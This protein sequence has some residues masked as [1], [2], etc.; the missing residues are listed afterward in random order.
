MLTHAW[1]RSVLICGGRG[2]KSGAQAHSQPASQSSFGSSLIELLKLTDIWELTYYIKL[3]FQ[4]FRLCPIMP[5]S[6]FIYKTW[7]LYETHK[8]AKS[9]TSHKSA[10][11]F[12]PGKNRI[13]KIR[14]KSGS[15]IPAIFD[16]ILRMDCQKFC[17]VVKHRSFFVILT[18]FEISKIAICQG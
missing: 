12:F 15:G 14:E 8:M 10:H 4:G 16:Q 6:Q 2:N 9:L 7:Y 11:H 1:T 17:F 3:H 18:D 5:Q 13:R